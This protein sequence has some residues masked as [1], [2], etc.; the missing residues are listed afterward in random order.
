[1]STEVETAGDGA[2]GKSI[3]FDFIG[4]PVPRRERKVMLEGRL[5]HGEHSASC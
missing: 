5:N 3:Q 1:M 2:E 4:G